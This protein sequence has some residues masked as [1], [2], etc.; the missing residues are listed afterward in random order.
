MR[1]ER[2]D[3]KVAV[4]VSYGFGAGWSTWVDVDE[5]HKDFILYGD[6]HLVELVRLRDFAKAEEYVISKIGDIY[7]TG[8]IY[9]VSVDWI[10]KGTKFF[11]DEYDGAETIITE[12]DIVWSVA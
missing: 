11:I 2:E 5:E 12:E 6:E 1:V 3:G 7:Y 4:L 9:E 10:D 8:G